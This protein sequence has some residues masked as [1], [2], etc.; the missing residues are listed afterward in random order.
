[1]ACNS[2]NIAI[3]YLK[4]YNKN[5]KYRNIEIK[6]SLRKYIKIYNK[7]YGLPIQF[8]GPILNGIY[9]YRC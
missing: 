6:I 7:K 8:R 3:C 9:E 1:L 4:V 2:I 5:I